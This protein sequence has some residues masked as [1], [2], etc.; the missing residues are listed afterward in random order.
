MINICNQF[1][2]IRC[3]DLEAAASRSKAESF[4]RVTAVLLVLQ[5]S[6]NGYLAMAQDQ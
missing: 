4:T 3:R 1:C 2:M 5:R 6:F